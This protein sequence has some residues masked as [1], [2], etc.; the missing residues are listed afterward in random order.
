MCILLYVRSTIIAK[1]FYVSVQ[2]LSLT[3]WMK[4]FTFKN[5]AKD[6]QQYKMGIIYPSPWN[7]ELWLFLVLKPEE[8]YINL[9]FPSILIFN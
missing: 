9:I 7:R 8:D 2:G 4:I 3:Q 6:S 5:R 1:Y